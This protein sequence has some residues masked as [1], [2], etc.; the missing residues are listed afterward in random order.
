MPVITYKT[1]TLQVVYV[2]ARR[3]LCDQC[4]RP[5]E[6]LMVGKTQSQ[7][8]SHPFASADSMRESLKKQV[9]KMLRS[10]AQAKRA[11]A[12]AC[13]F[14]HYFQTWM[15]TSSRL[16]WMFGLGITGF[17]L[18]GIVSLGMESVVP[19]VV[20]VVLLTALGALVALK[21]KPYDDKVT[22]RARSDADYHAMIEECKKQGYDVSLYWYSQTGGTFPEKTAVIP[23]PPVDLTGAA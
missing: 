20:A 7:V 18:G 12:E 17:V 4:S 9:D 2:Q 13:P 1:M 19:V 8:A 21:R 10:K 22:G 11:G 3:I 16:K 15:V 14:C 6:Y 5:F 23:L